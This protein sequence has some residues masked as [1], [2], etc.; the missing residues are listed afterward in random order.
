MMK[1]RKI[2]GNKIGKDGMH[3][4]M[5]KSKGDIIF[6]TFYINI[7]H[8]PEAKDWKMGKT[9]EVGLRLRMTGIE[10]RKN[11]GKDQDMGSANFEIIGIAPGGESKE[12]T[13]RY[14]EEK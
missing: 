6:P 9:Y 7:E 14:A 2:E 13:S 11:E 3:P 1:M 10:I 4:E 12:K 5:A 8:L